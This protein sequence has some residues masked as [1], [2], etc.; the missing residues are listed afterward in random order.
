MN[1]NKDLSAYPEIV[2]QSR[3]AQ[4]A[5]FATLVHIAP[6]NPIVAA[7]RSTLRGDPPADLNAM[8]SASLSSAFL[9]FTLLSRQRTFRGGPTSSPSPSKVDN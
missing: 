4:Q 9:S 5:R 3:F 2:R 6:P 7:K 1:R 8:P